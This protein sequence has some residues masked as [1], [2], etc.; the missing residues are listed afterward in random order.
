[1][2]LYLDTSALVKRYFQEPGSAEVASA[3]TRSVEI[4]ISSVGYAEAVASINRKGRESH[5]PGDSLRWILKRLQKDWVSFVRIQV[6]DE[7]NGWIDRV[8]ASH[9]LR[10]F[11]AIHLASALVIREAF[12]ENLLFACFDKR[13]IN[14][15]RAEGL[16]TLPVEIE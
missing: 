7:L 10:G 15:A 13:L 5:I 11:D 4:T 2:I 12:P 16:K 6:T 1:M 9:A 8:L 14:A 3:W